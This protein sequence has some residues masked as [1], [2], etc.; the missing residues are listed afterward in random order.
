MTVTETCKFFTDF[1]GLFFSTRVQRVA[2][3]LLKLFQIWI[4][5]HYF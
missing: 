2:W 3:N 5:C 1:L 4:Y